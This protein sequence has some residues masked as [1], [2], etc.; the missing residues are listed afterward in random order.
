[1]TSTL[2]LPLSSPARPARAPDRLRGGLG[3]QQVGQGEAGVPFLEGRTT[4]GRLGRA[5]RNVPTALCPPRTPT[6]GHECR[7]HPDA[8][9]GD[10]GGVRQLSRCSRGAHDRDHLTPARIE[11]GAGRRSHGVD[12]AAPRPLPLRHARPAGSLAGK[13]DR[14]RAQR[15]ERVLK[16][17]RGKAPANRGSRPHPETRGEGVTGRPWRMPLCPRG[18]GALI[19][20]TPAKL[21]DDTVGGLEHT[22]SK[23][24]SS[25]SSSSS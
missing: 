13:R 11:V 1:M 20:S 21:P 22:A 5:R 9:A 19:V 4:G 17:A 18:Q 24:E 8:H 14:P 16:L 25:A 6:A 7:R 3:G 23:M 2:R 10:L 12:V 15:Q